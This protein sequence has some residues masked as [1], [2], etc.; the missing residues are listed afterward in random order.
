MWR[1]ESVSKLK[2]HLVLCQMLNRVRVCLKV[3]RGGYEETALTS[4]HFL[5]RKSTDLPRNQ[6][7]R[8]GKR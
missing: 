1:V 6:G 4:Y 3:G 2:H 8:K 7:R 5:Y